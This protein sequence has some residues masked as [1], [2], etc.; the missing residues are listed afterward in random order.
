MSKEHTAG[1][2][3]FDGKN[4]QEVVAL[5]KYAWALGCSDRIASQYAKISQASLSRYLQAKPDIAEEKMRLKTDPILKAY[6]SVNESFANNPELAFK[7]L[8]RVIPEL[9]P[10]IQGQIEH[11]TIHQVIVELLETDKPKQID[12]EVIEDEQQVDDSD[13]PDVV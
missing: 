6:K 7:Y 10:K 9:T 5:L 11:K 1:R 8:S 3:W 12:A 2:Y 4:E 13:K